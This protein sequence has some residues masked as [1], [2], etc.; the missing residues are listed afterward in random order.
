M[1]HAGASERRYN[2]S[3]IGS[4]SGIRSR[5]GPIDKDGIAAYEAVLTSL[6]TAENATGYDWAEE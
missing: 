5:T 3:K 1:C 4:C 6:Q 2:D